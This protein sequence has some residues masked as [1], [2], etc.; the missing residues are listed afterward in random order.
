LHLVCNKQPLKDEPFGRV[1]ISFKQTQ[2]TKGNA[3][4]DR[5]TDAERA[6]D[7]QSELEWIR[8]QQEEADRKTAALK[9]ELERMKAAAQSGSG[10][11]NVRGSVTKA[12]LPRIEILREATRL[13]TPIT[14]QQ[15]MLER[16]GIVVSYN[17]LR[18][19]IQKFLAR[20]YREFLANVR[21]TGADPDFGRELH[22]E[23][24]RKNHPDAAVTPPV[25]A[26]TNPVERGS[27][28]LTNIDFE[29]AATPRKL[30]DK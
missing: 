14:Q 19:F 9:A 28:S 26:E 16:A 27:A 6:R 7:E 21:T 30:F 3:M 25:K 10:Q 4:Y 8:M 11:K 1:T 20:E 12:L 17:S 18:K 5:R 22:P 29:A 15:E 23:V 2:Q 13:G 24:I